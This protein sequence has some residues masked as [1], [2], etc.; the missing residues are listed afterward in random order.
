MLHTRLEKA[1]KKAG[2]EIKEVTE[3]QRAAVK[4]KNEI[5][6]RIQGGTAICVRMPNPMTDIMTDCF[7]DTYFDSIKG[8]VLA[9]D[10]K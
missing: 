1:M 8:A 6:W 3:F 7:C 5:H 9:L 4:G 2:A 10:W